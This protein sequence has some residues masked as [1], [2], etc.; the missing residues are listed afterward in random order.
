MTFSLFLPNIGSTLAVNG[1][2][3]QHS[4]HLRIS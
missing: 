1:V 3:L 2:P 4:M